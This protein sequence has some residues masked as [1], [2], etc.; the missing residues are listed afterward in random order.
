MQNRSGRKL[1]SGIPRRTE[2]R[3]GV[4]ARGLMRVHAKSH[5][6]EHI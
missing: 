1:V 6:S 4:E 3:L 2:P 5:R